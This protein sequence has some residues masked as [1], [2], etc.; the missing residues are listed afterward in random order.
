MTDESWLTVERGDAPLLVSLPAHRLEHPAGL[1]GRLVSRPLAR[2]DTDWHIDRLYAFARDLGATTVHTALSRTVIDVNRDPSGAS[3]YPGQA[4]T[5][6]VPDRRPSTASRS[7]ATARR[8]RRPRS[9]A[10]RR[11]TSRPI[12]RRSPPRSRALRAMHTAR[13]ALRLPFDPL[14]DPAPVRRRTAGCSTSAP[15]TA[16]ACDP[17]LARARSSVD[18]RR[19]PA[20]R[21]SST[22]ASRAAGSPATTASPADG[23]HAVQMEL[24]LRGYL[25]RGRRPS[26]TTPGQRRL[27]AGAS[28]AI[29]RAR[30][31]H[32]A[33]ACPR[34]DDGPAC[35]TRLDNARDDPRRRA[36]PRSPPRA[37]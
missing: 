1:R 29:L 36:A 22:A 19:E 11:A 26:P 25:R 33:L 20:G 35:T 32:A 12:T 27:D 24:A 30:S 17:A 8:R 3:L 13:R 10:A 34:P 28:R 23:V 16:R 2:Q 4:T 21:T 14:G 9:S 6:L 5:G 18:L 7:I 31:T 37:G 15:T